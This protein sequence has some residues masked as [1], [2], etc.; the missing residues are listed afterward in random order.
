MPPLR[1]D[2]KADKRRRILACA[3]E[4]FATRGFDAT[5]I[6]SIASASGVGLGTVMAYA[7]TKQM[8]LQDIWRAEIMPLVEAS[9]AAAVGQPIRQAAMTLFVPLLRAY[10]A[11]R[12]IAR[13][14]VKELPWL[15]GSAL[16]AHRFDLTRLLTALV[17]SVVS[18]QARGEVRG[19]VDPRCAAELL[20]SVYYASCLRLL[21]EA[22]AQDVESVI[23]SLQASVDLVFSGLEVS[24]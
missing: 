9:C 23:V 24:A 22:S 18:A 17:Q 20:F 3:R 7:E 8:L 1:E 5:T 15:E 6:R 14:A 21:T 2:Q 10:A 4:Q 12:A 11:Q 16:Q 19:S 13:V